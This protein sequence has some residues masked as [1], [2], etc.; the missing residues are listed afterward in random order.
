MAHQI[1]RFSDQF[2]FA[3]TADCDKGTIA[4]GDNTPVVGTGYQTLTIVKALFF[5]CNGL[6]VS[7]FFSP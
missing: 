4:M 6:I 2:F 7:H 5:L 3:E 1:M